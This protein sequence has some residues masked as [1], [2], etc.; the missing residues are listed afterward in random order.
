M[1]QLKHDFGLMGGEG[2]RNEG[3][4]SLTLSRNEKP[5]AFI[6]APADNKIVTAHLQIP[7]WTCGG[8]N[9]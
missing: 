4:V 3:M 8:G 6:T 9:I 2:V 1:N 7:W 5:V